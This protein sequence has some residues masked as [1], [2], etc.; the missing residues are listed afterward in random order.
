MICYGVSDVLGSYGFGYIIKHTGRVPC[1]IFA[2]LVNYV[3]MAVLML[4]TP[5]M[6]SSSVLYLI[7]V[8]WGMSD[9]V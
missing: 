1:F 3:S 9:A 2:G 4:W 6:A 8:M 7:A 5:S